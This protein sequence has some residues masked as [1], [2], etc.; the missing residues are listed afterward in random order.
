[1]MKI[2]RSLLYLD[3]NYWEFQGK[4]RKKGKETGKLAT[5]L[6]QKINYKMIGT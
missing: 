4:E 2:F 6:L 5:K 3:V 1:M